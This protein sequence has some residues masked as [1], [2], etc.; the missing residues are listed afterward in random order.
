MDGRFDGVDQ[1]L[2]EHSHHLARLDQAFLGLDGKVDTLDVR[3]SGRID[4]LER[5]MLAGFDRL[6]HRMLNLAE[7]YVAMKEGMRRLEQGPPR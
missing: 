2:D 4:G 7:D 6:E 1:R 5:E 3:L